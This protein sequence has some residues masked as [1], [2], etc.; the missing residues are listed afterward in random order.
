M[1]VGIV[2]IYEP[3]SNLGSYL[4][5]YALKTVLEEMGHEVW[6][7]QNMSTT[8]NL[9]KL[10]FRLN[11]KREIL[12]RFKKAL[13]AWKDIKRLSLVDKRKMNDLDLLVYGSDEIWNIDTVYFSNS[14]FWGEGAKIPHIAYAVSVGVAQEDHLGQNQ[15]FIDNVKKFKK[16][17]VR[18]HRTEQILQNIVGEKFNSVCD[19][20]MLVPLSRLS[21]Y[22]KPIKE[23]YLLVYTYGIDQPMI[24]HIRSFAKQRGLT[25]VSACFW[26]IW[27][28][29]VVECSA[30][31]VSTLM[32]NAEYVFTSTFHGAVFTMLNH[33]CCCILPVRPKVSEVVERMGVQERLIDKD[34]DYAVFENTMLKEFDSDAFESTLANYRADSLR[35]L[36]EALE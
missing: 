29:R 25:V 7:V 22:I 11:P 9:S 21:E 13:H 5:A 28:D 16:I 2:T 32:K 10:I 31:Q 35:Q 27:A 34:C 15:I 4:Q 33:K 12:L 8:K 26:H 23:K 18:D 17:L 14:F 3:T 6:M 24:D 30:L 19:P 1:K 36:K 20:T